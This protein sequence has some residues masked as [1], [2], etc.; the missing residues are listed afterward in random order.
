MTTIATDQLNRAPGTLSRALRS[1]EEVELTFHERPYARVV[2]HD[3]LER[4]RAELAKLRAEVEQL[5]AR[6]GV[7]T[8]A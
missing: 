5:R 6:L 2:P 8:A 1:G 7:D 3:D 4:E